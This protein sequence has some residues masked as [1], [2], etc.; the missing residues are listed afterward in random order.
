MSRIA[1]AIYQIIKTYFP[2][3]VIVKEHYV[4]YKGNRLFFD[5]FIKDL[6][7]LIEVQGRQHI[8]Y[9]PHFHEDK[10]K[11]LAQKKRDN[12]KIEY[13][14]ENDKYCLVRFYFNE[15]FTEEIVVN[16]IYKALNSE[17]NFYE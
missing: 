5:Y 13:V 6:G 2:L 11:F 17:D 8:D 10:E 9:V 3:N 12:L 1:K 14:Q 7:V 15:K 16:K 4:N